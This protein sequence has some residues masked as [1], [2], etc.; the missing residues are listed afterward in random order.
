MRTQTQYHACIKYS[1][2]MTAVQ[3]R[4]THYTTHQST[5]SVCLYVSSEQT[6][7][8]V[9]DTGREINLVQQQT[10]FTNTVQGRHVLDWLISLLSS[11][12]TTHKYQRL[13]NVKCKQALASDY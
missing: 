12:N 7:N 13:T 11:D 8:A 3:Y 9:F 4:V 5:A 10:A 2:E 6:V 1:N